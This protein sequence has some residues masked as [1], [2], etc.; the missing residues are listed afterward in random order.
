MILSCILLL[1]LPMQAFAAEPIDT[2]KNVVLTIQYKHEGTPVT[3]IPFHLYRVADI[4]SDNTFKLT[5]DFK[6]YPVKVNELSSSDW[7]ALADTLT[8]YVLRDGLKPLNSGITDENGILSFPTGGTLRPGLFLVIGEHAA[9]DGFDYTTE[10]FLICL[11]NLD[12]AGEVWEYD[13]GVTPKYIRRDISIIP[14]QSEISR[15][16]LKVWEDD[17]EEGRPEKVTVSLLCDDE[18]YETVE[19]DE[20]NSWQFLW[21]EL[22][23]Y[24]SDGHAIE[25]RI[26]E[27]E[28]KGYTV[29]M[30]RE[31]IT[32]VVTNT[33]SPD[34]PPDNPPDTPPDTPPDLPYTGMLWWPVPLLACAG[35]LF[36]LAGR[37][38][39]KRKA[40]E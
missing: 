38:V 36:L 20:K 4:S 35:L 16:V 23:E 14:P 30:R 39:G 22:P 3:G 18:V 28:V 29:A 17:C 2:T 31:G 25:W 10:P 19:L 32:F 27:N 7:K 8:G 26:V 9:V 6:N 11:P 15:K 1:L 40:D 24:G 13:V 34:M 5:G 33:K 21:T 37:L 12:A